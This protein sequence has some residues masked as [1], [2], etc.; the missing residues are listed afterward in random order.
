LHWTYLYKQS[1][2]LIIEHISVVTVDEWIDGSY[3]SQVGGSIPESP[4]ICISRF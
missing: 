3:K 2:I 1:Y 4:K